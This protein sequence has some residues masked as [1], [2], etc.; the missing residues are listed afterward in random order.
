MGDS[1]ACSLLCP[2]IQVAHLRQRFFHSIAPGGL[3]GDRRGVVLS[4][5]FSLSGQQLWKVIKENRDLDLS[6]H[7]V[8][9]ATV[10]CEEIAS[11][12]LR[13]L[14]SDERWLALEDAVQSGPVPGFGNKL[15]SILDTY[16]FEYDMEAFCFDELVRKAKRQQLESKALQL[17]EIFDS[18]LTRASSRYCEHVL[19]VV[20]QDDYDQCSEVGG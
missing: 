17:A 13:R 11:D 16:L 19:N 3:A 15:R 1:Q 20:L 6:A 5:G 7:K 9:V 8:M 10:R 12:K 4:S 2:L 14:S 18:S